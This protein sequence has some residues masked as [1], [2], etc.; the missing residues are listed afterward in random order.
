M[1]EKPIARRSLMSNTCSC[2]KTL[3][4]E[5]VGCD[6]PVEDSR[7]ISVAKMN[8]WTKFIA[9]KLCNTHLV[10]LVIEVGGKLDGSAVKNIP[11]E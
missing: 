7:T 3:I 5:W 4:C 11:E 9:V 1:V 8:P 2:G 10:Q 6:H